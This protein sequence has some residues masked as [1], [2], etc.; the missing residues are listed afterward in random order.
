MEKKNGGNAMANM[1]SLSIREGVRERG[2][3]GL[4]DKE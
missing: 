2:Y 4:I 1:F 3:V